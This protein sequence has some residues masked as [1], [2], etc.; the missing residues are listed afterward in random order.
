M[1]INYT[2]ASCPLGRLLMAATERGVCLVH[3]GDSDRD[4]LRHLEADFPEAQFEP[5]NSRLQ[6]WM[7]QLL[8][9]LEGKSDAAC[10]PIDLRGTAFQSRV[11]QELRAIPRGETCSYREVARRIGNPKAFRAV[12][13]ACATNPVAILI[14]CHRVVQSDGGLGGYGGGLER[15]RRLLEMEKQ[16]C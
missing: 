6:S 16:S 10:I 4:L 1:R 2:I 7:T 11:W 14:P 3:L 12:A 8:G 5:S 15:K 9:N 13:R